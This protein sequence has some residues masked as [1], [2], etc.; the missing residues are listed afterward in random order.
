MLHDPSALPSIRMPL[1]ASPLASRYPEGERQEMAETWDFQT[2]SESDAVGEEEERFPAPSQAE[3]N[4][5]ENVPYLPWPRAEILPHKHKC[6]C[7]PLGTWGSTWIF[8]PKSITGI[9]LPAGS[10]THSLALAGVSQRGLEVFLL[11][12][13][14]CA[15][16][17]ASH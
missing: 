7:K 15:N 1:F 11:T 14:G 12:A 10:I 9:T 8:P 2:F 5:L 3:I 6:P 16:Q 13:K 17:S 4:R